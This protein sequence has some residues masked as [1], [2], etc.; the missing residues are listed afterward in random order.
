LTRVPSGATGARRAVQ[1]TP[2]APTGSALLLE[3]GAVFL[4]GTKTRKT[5]ENTGF[6]KVF[7]SKRS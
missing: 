1:S 5:L 2:V 7:A 3:T 4:L 6:S